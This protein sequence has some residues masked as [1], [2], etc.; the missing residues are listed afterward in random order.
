MYAYLRKIAKLLKS[1]V[2]SKQQACHNG[3]GVV[4]HFFL[5]TRNYLKIICIVLNSIF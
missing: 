5:K 3:R 4:P 1:T 2:S